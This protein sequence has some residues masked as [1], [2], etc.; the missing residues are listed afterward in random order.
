MPARAGILICYEVIYPALARD[1]VGAGADL[2]VNLSND[3]W[4]DAGA[5]PAQHYALA[6]FRAVENGVA[7]LRATNSGVSGAFD[8]NGREI[9]RLPA[10][11]AA[12]APSSAAR[13]AADPSTRAMA[14]GSRGLVA[15]VVAAVS[16]AANDDPDTSRRAQDC[17]QG[18]IHSAAFIDAYSSPYFSSR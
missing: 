17:S 11:V 1:A 2:L 13:A 15:L 7:L 5:G 16:V 3:S 9:A 14:T 10:D 6:R 12:A 4:F 18:R 8:P